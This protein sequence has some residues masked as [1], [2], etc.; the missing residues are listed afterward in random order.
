M[1]SKQKVKDVH[2]ICDVQSKKSGARAGRIITPHGVI[3]TPSFVAVGTNGTLKALDNVS[4]VGMG[5]ELMFCNT[6]HLLVH[7]GAEVVESCGGLH[8]F[9]Q[10]QAPIITDS[11]GFQVFS[12]A[13]GSVADELKSCGKKKSTSSVISIKE[14]GVK[15][16]SYRD[17]R[18]IL[19]TPE[20]S[21]AAQKS[22]GSDIMI[23]FDELPPFHLG[24]DA[25]KKS[26]ERTHRWMRRSWQYH[27]QHPSKSGM[28]GVVHGG[29]DSDLRRQSLKLLMR[30]DWDGFAL[31]GSFGRDHHDLQQVLE[32]TSPYMPQ[33]YPRH[34]L[35]IGDIKGVDMAV[36]YGM[37]TM[38]SSYPTKCAR[39]GQV[40]RD[41][42]AIKIS[43]SRWARDCGP[44]DPT[45]QCYTCQN[46]SMAYLHHL[47]KMKEPV[48]AMLASTH[49]IAFMIKY[50]ADIR[51][52]I[53]T[54]DI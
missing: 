37:D 6:Y 12:L 47:F 35:G 42:Q 49:N 24:I 36:H 34:L 26:F 5:L 20:S 38:D 21:V 48:F 27:Q 51:D 2:Y 16:R 4:V 18:E 53:I 32:M 41:G 7:P 25:L 14:Q 30:D 43:Q 44:I 46:Y 11:G 29:L 40:F 9:I 54:G 10:R 28:Y 45:C 8:N 23:P 52:K 31:G 3:H 15:F 17:G 19:L 22:F 33:E 50:M 13:Y 1:T 39:H